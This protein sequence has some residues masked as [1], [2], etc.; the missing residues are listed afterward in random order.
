MK[1]KSI[2]KNKNN[3]FDRKTIAHAAFLRGINVG[4]HAAVKMDDLR[5]TFE[6]LEFANVKTVLASGNVLFEI[7]PADTAALT[8][9]IEQKL[10][11]AF[12]WDIGVILRTFKEIQRIMDS[13]P[14]KKIPVTPQTRLY[15]TFLSEKP[16]KI[17][18]VPFESPKK[19]FRIL[20]V[21]DTEVLSVLTLSPES[22]TTDL[23]SYI[24]K[25]F[26]RKITTRNWNTIVKIL[27]KQ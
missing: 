21:S 11:K 1:G 26:G 18:P 16:G 3:S 19:D 5:K 9:K 10:K 14:F 25:E 24:E 8:M 22:Q 20:G 7:A 27:G 15:I 6:S 4:G 17:F 12:G 2:M 23:M 13:N